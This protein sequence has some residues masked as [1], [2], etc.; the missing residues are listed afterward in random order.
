MTG[1]TLPTS[2]DKLVHELAKSVRGLVITPDCDAYDRAVLGFNRIVA[3]RPAAVAQ[4]I[5]AT[6]VAATMR[7]AA[8]HD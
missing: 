7:V 8:K 3:S 5:D 6:D 2:D 1:P 4:V